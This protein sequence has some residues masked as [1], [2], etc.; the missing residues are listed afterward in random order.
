MKKNISAWIII[1]EKPGNANQAIAV[2]NA[3]SIDYKIKKLKYNFLGH[4]PNWLK[5]DSLLGVDLAL[6]DNI[7]E[8]THP[9]LVI[10]SGRKTAAVCSYIKKMQP[11]TFAVHL[12]HPDLPFENF[13][14]VALPFHDLTE[15]Y[16]TTNNIVYTVGAPSYLEANKLRTAKEELHTKI[17]E[18]KGPFVTLI[19]GGKTKTG[20]YSLQEFQELVVKAS[21]ITNELSGSLLITTSRRTDKEMSKQLKNYI[22]APCFFYDWHL[23]EAKDN[24]YLG[25][26]SLSDYII[27]TGDSVSICSE[28]LSTGNPVYVYRKDKLLYKKHIKFLDYLAQLGYTRNLEDTSKLEKWQYTPLKEAERLGKIINEKLNASTDISSENS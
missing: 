19:I 2:A 6:S 10:S 15:K 28:A 9:D 17:S 5:F 4:L 12:M 8:E 27:V 26:L 14:L 16:A 7:T 23:E 1:D 18:L 25:M 11:Q 21:L 3:M 20:N 13:D 22:T 24:P